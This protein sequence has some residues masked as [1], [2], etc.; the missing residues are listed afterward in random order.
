MDDTDP[1]NLALMKPTK[2]AKIWENNQD[3]FGS[4]KAVDGN[5]NGDVHKGL[6]C[7]WGNMWWLV[8]LQAIYL[9]REV[10]VTNRGDRDCESEYVDDRLLRITGYIGTI[11]MGI[12]TRLYLKFVFNVYIKSK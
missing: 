3:K 12:E 4:F 11:L 8:D 9:I 10:A 7:A 5:K 1:I 6:S 2:F